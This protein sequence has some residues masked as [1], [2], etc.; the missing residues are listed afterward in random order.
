[1]FP[2]CRSTRSCALDSDVVDETEIDDVAA[3]LRVDHLTQRFPDAI[4][5]AAPTRIL[6]SC[7]ECLSIFMQ[8][9][10][11]TIYLFR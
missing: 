2:P 4:G 9:A 5:L 10:I 6:D 7:C 11:R 8:K 3:E 1:L